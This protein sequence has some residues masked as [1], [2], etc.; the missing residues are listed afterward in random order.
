MQ[1]KKRKKRERTQG[2]YVVWS[3]GL[4][5]QFKFFD[6]YIFDIRTMHITMNH[7]KV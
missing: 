1:E 4:P 3:A 5:L 7:S 6:G 2:G